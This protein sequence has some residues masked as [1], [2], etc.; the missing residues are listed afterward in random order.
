M[1]TLRQRAEIAETLVDSDC[2]RA[3]WYFR[4]RNGLGR[5]VLNYMVTPRDGL[6]F[7]G[8]GAMDMPLNPGGQLI[9]CHDFYF[10]SDGSLIAILK[11]EFEFDENVELSNRRAME[12]AFDFQT[13]SGLFRTVTPDDEANLDRL[14]RSSIDNPTLERVV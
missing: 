8:L 11:S 7:Y 2:R 9:P 13:Q 1:N 14:L 6:R 3:S 12:T 10:L 5:V 4:Y